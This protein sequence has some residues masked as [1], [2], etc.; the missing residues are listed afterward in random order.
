MVD[1][2]LPNNWRARPYQAKA[3]LALEQCIIDGGPVRR[4]SLAWHRRAGKDDIALHATAVASQLRIAPYWHM[5]PLQTQ[6][7]KAIW[8][9]VDPHT[10]KRRVDIAFPHEMRKRTLD[11]EMFIEFHNGSTWQAL[12]SDNPDALVGAP[13]AGIVS[14]EHALA[15]PNT[16]G[17]LRPILRENNG[18]AAFISTPRG[19]NHFAR[20][21][22]AALTDPAWFGQT[23]TA[24]D[25]GVF[26]DADLAAELREMCREHGAQDGQAL[27]D[28][29]YS[30]S[31]DAALQGAYYGA[32]M[33]SLEKRGQIG[34]QYAWSPRFPVYVS[35]DLG[36]LDDSALWFFQIINGRVHVID[37]Y[38]CANVGPE[39]YVGWM[40]TRP[41]TYAEPALLLPHDGKKRV[42]APGVPT[43]EQQFRQLSGGVFGG[44]KCEVVPR[45]PNLTAAINTTRQFIE[46]CHFNTKPLPAEGFGGG[47][48][49]T[50]DDARERMARGLDALRQ[51]RREWDAD[52]KRFIDHPLHDWTSHPADA[53]R[54]MA[55]SKVAHKLAAPLAPHGAHAQMAYDPFRHAPAIQRYA[56]SN[57]DDPFGGSR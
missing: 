29:E 9:A 17:Y 3:W 43:I 52:L 44:W 8:N 57:N 14:S 18:W 36:I 24:A 51:Y 1:L 55:C 22:R 21:H 41:Y 27:F 11:N 25:T 39:H 56:A 26:S 47:M 10:G 13:P 30:C 19:N 20:M 32:V 37:Y 2:T 50:E 16:W 54:T 33:R 35:S 28:Q 23:L 7:R 12:G 38:D 46:T 48:P 34:E 40:R 53:M 5:L 15:N 49:E 42:F 4:F 31:F 45:T 6:V